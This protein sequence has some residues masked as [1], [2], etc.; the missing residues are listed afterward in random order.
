MITSGGVNPG[1]QRPSE[2]GAFFSTL[3]GPG[4]DFLSSS[5][6]NVF[7]ANTNT[8]TRREIDHLTVAVLA[9]LTV[10]EVGIGCTA[11]GFDFNAYPA[12]D[13]LSVM[14]EISNFYTGFSTTITM[15]PATIAANADEDLCRYLHRRIEARGGLEVS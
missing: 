9:T 15:V 3:F 8:G 10:G 7:M 4:L 11:S 2:R 14:I 13:G 12:T 5:A 6:Y 1:F